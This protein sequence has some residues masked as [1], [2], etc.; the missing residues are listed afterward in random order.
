MLQLTFFKDSTRGQ[1]PSSHSTTTA[2][3]ASTT[4]SD[5]HEGDIAHFAQVGFDALVQ[6]LAVQQGFQA[7]VI[8]TVY[9]YLSSYEKTV[10]V[11][12]AMREAAEVH[13][14]A[15]ILSRTEGDDVEDD[16]IMDD[17]VKEDSV[18]SEEE[19]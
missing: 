12:E 1:Q 11:I 18:K 8:R 13:A 9:K 4:H 6:S 15:E 7:D 3:G 17:S 10:E 2:S 5:I 19:E 14:V 16:S